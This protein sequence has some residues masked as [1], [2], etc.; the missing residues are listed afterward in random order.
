MKVFVGQIN[1]TIGD[2]EGNAGLI[3]AA[4]ER[5]RAAGAALAAFPEMALPGYPPRDLL[6][7][8]EFVGRTA[9]ALESLRPAT[10]GL[11]AVIGLMEPNPGEGRPLFNSAAVLSDGRR[12]ASARKCLIPA[13]DVFDEDRYFESSREP[14]VVDVP[15][16]G[17]ARRIGLSI[18]EDIWND[19]SYWKHRRYNFDPILVQ[20]DRGAQ[21]LVNISASPFHQGKDRLRESMLGEVA[22]RHKLPL[23]YANLVGA[24]DDLVFDGRSLAFDEAGRLVGR[25]KAYEVDDLIVELDPPSGTIQASCAD[26]VESVYRALVLGTRDYMSKCGFT[27]AVLGLSGGIDSSLVACLAAEA[28]GPDKVRGVALPSRYSSDH[29]LE[30]ARLLAQALGLRFDVISIDRVFQS[31]LDTLSPAFAGRASDVTEENLQSRIRGATLMALSNKFGSL[32]LT[33]GNKSEL[34]VG[35]CTLYGDMCGGLSVIADVPKM[36]VYALS[37]HANRRRPVIPERVFTKAPSAELKPDQTDQD[38]LPPYDVLDAILER[39][40]EGE[41]SAAEIVAAG[42]PQPVVEQVL[43]WMDR[44]EFKRRQAAPGLKVTSRAFGIGRRMPIAQRYPTTMM[45]LGPEGHA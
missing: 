1:P 26:D 5:A 14:L 3:R 17:G 43:R 33:T 27:T 42:F 35:Y 11:T 6:L 12:L 2:L 41:A 7:R 25:G 29:S 22:R 38:T 44:S 24:N 23:I 8:R 15:S 4:L 45:P 39:A 32:L 20:A 18:C 28:I 31:Y 40:I 16:P 13:Y 37:R 10:R 9:A 36:L 34:G 21:A 19:R 30:D